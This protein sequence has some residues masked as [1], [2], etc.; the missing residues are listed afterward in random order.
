MSS[1][2]SDCVGLTQASSVRSQTRAGFAAGI[3]EGMLMSC[4]GDWLNEM[5]LA[6]GVGLKTALWPA[7]QAT[8]LVVV[9]TVKV[10]AGATG[11]TTTATS[12]EPAPRSALA[13]VVLTLVA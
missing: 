11:A 6:V 1:E 12:S 4:A 9:G 3:P 8:G 2:T 7:V 13:R 10:V 5:A